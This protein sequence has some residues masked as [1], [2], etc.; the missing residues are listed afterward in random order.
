MCS[1]TGGSSRNPSQ[2]KATK[3]WEKKKTCSTRCA[4][5]PIELPE[6]QMSNEKRAPGCLVYI[7]GM[8]FPTQLYWDYFINHEIRIPKKPTSSYHG[9]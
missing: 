5:A 4:G 6:L 2:F 8:T 7:G 1:V 9:K 3:N